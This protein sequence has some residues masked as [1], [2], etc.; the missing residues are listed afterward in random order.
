MTSN[1]A[2]DSSLLH[3]LDGLARLALGHLLGFRVGL[4]IL[5]SQDVDK[6]LLLVRRG[7]TAWKGSIG[8]RVEVGLASLNRDYGKIERA[9]TY[10]WSI[11]PGERGTNRPW[12]SRSLSWSWNWRTDGVERARVRSAAM[13][14][15]PGLR[16]DKNHT[17]YHD[18]YCLWSKF[19]VRWMS[20]ASE[21]ECC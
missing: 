5:L 15:V 6:A 19:D 21:L 10:R 13:R 17:T 14:A 9:G 16:P 2:L 12:G 7:F 8:I 20:S 3:L 11:S 4:S 1:V 18:E